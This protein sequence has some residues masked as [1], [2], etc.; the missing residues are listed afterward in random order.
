MLQEIAKLLK[1]QQQQPLQP[2]LS[3]IFNMASKAISSKANTLRL[4]VEEYSPPI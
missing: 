2:Q 4:P 1:A 3:S